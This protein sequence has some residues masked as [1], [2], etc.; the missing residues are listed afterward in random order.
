MSH[1]LTQ[2]L[3]RRRTLALLAAGVALPGM[4]PGAARAFIGSEWL[5]LRIEMGDLPPV[6]DRL[7]LT[8]RVV[9]LAAM[10]RVPGRH[11]GT[12]RMLIGGQRDERYMPINGYSRLVGYDP[13]LNMVADILSSW[14][15][16]GDRMFTLHLRPGHRWSDGHPFTAEDFRYCW[17]DVALHD[18][19]GGIPPELK[20]NGAG[21]VFEMLDPVTVRYTWPA[22]QPDFLPLLA[23]PVPQRVFMPAHYMKQFHG[24]YADPVELDRLVAANRVD[25]WQSL[26]M[27]MGRSS[28]P[29]NPDLPTLEP[30]RPRSA[31]PAQQ[32]VFERNPFFHRVDEN[33]RQ[34]PYIDRVVLNVSSYDIIPAKVAT[35]DSDL[36]P[37]GIEFSDYTLVKEA[38]SRF[39]LKVDLWTRS[40]GSRVAL[41]PNLT[42]AD[43]VWRALYRDVRVRRAMSLA[44]DRTEINKALFFGL[45]RE[46]ANTV[47]PQSPLYRAEYATAWTGFDPEQANALLDQAALSAIRADG[48]RR[49]PDGRMAG[50]VVESA[51]ESTLETDVLE[52]V[53]DHFRQIG[54]ALWPRVSQRDLFRSR[55]MAGT[56]S[57]SVWTGLD[58][59]VP[60][61]DMPPYELAPTSEDQYI[62]PQWGVHYASKGSQ[63]SAPDLPEVQQLVDLVHHWR[64]SRSHDERAEIWHRMLAIHADQVFSIGTVNGAQQ[65][66]VHSSRLRNVPEH[67]LIG[68]QPTSIL[69]IYMPDT[70]W[71]EAES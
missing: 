18:G 21:P 67:G 15:T 30:W 59:A 6:Q 68:F 64:R 36:Q 47:L 20:V 19:M 58:N 39:P 12:V 57:M 52:L 13:D 25:D 41:L 24:D 8:P 43:P 32:F 61:A 31:P 50:I 56:I 42:C 17:Q 62:W 40:Q 37:F 66:V 16:V 60:T 33:G 5:D 53:A 2:R 46:S 63:G 10:G 55:S 9:N 1:G 71:Y 44:I 4:M 45:A 35:G 54:I 3:T 65:P 29:E 11:G 26:H 27:K 69:G 22:P 28:R 14:E 70:F 7:P 34:L 49:L 48:Y 38:E 23:A 51:G